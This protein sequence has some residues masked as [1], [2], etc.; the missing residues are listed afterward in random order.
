MAGPA[1]EKQLEVIEWAL[2]Y[3]S[4]E[5]TVRLESQTLDLHF[6][7]GRGGGDLEQRG[8]VMSDEDLIYIWYEANL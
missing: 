6:P 1:I 2:Q 8:A 7:M 3:S 5:R 4:E